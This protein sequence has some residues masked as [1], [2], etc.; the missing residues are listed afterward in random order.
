M[1]NFS[2]LPWEIRDEIWK[3][4]PRDDHP[5]VHIFGHYDEKKKNTPEGRS[6]MHG[7][8]FSGILS[9][10]PPHRY[11]KSLREGCDD[12]NIST[13]LIDGAMWTTCKES[14]LVMEK[15]FSQYKWPTYADFFR[16]FYRDTREFI[17]YPYDE[18]FQVPSTG[19]FQGNSPAYLTVF[20]R[21]DLFVF[22]PDTLEGVD[23]YFVGSGPT[24]GGMRPPFRR[25]QH[26]AIEYNP[27]WWDEMT[28]LPDRP[29]VNNL[30]NGVFELRDCCKLWFIDTSLKRKMDAPAFEENSSDYEKLNAFYARDRKFLEV[31]CID[32]SDFPEDWEYAKPVT[33]TS[34]R[35]R[36]FSVDFFRQ[37]Q[38]EIWYQYR[39]AVFRAKHFNAGNVLHARSRS[40]HCKIGLLGCDE[41]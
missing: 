5:G 41:L 12:E 28:D 32:G 2:D 26:I 13:Y 25:L 29:N 37:L 33:D 3:P 6:M 4:V 22:Q 34:N 23:W 38:E 18:V 40:A 27:K 21:R 19:Y 20:P 14:R 24:R 10:P 31:D 17:G 15:H 1:T 9:E 39:S 11:F 30:I 35:E 8:L 36:S 7:N 16:R